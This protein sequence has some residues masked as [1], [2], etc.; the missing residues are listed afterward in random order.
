MA[1]ISQVIPNLLGGVSQQPDPLKLPGQVR[2][3]ENAL[4]DPTFGCRKRP[5]TQFIAKLADDIPTDARWFEIFRDQDERY[6]VSIYRTDTTTAIRVW[7]ADTG[8]ERTVNILGDTAEYLDAGDLQSIKT[9]T[10]NDYTLLTN[11]EKVVN[12]SNDDTQ[13][14]LSEALIVINQVAYNTTYSIDF[15]KTD[16][17][18]Q[19]V[20]IYYATSLSISPGTFEE[21]DE[22]ACGKAD[23]QNFIEDSTDGTK[24]ELGF[25]IT[26]NC[27][28]TQVQEKKP[29]VAYPTAVELD[30]EGSEQK[31]FSDIHGP[32]GDIPQG[33]YVYHDN[34]ENDITFRV[35]AK[36]VDDGDGGND[37]ELTAVQI[38]SYNENAD[39]EW[40][41][42][43]KFTETNDGVKG[44]YNITNISRGQEQIEYSYKSSYRTR[45]TLTNGGFGWKT[46]D[47]VSVTMAGK[48]YKVTVESHDFV[49]AYQAESSVAYTTAADTSGGT[50][51]VD[52]IVSSLTAEIQA[53]SSYDAEPIGNVIY[54]KRTDD[55]PFN[56]Q[57]RGG[58]VGNA[59]YGIKGT[60]NDVSRLPEQGKAGMVLK[61]Q[62][63]VDTSADDYYVK[64]KPN[65][66]DIPGQ[67]SW[68]ETVA[69]GIDT[70]LN[71]STMPHAMVREAD[72]TFSVRPL[73][74]EY[75]ETLFWAPRSAG[76][77][78]SNPP[79]TFVGQTI[80]QMFF[81]QNRL[82]FLSSDSVV[83][84]QPGDYFNFFAGS[85][86]TVSDA[87]PID[88]SV[89][90]TRPATLK[91]AL[92]TAQGLLLFAEN[93]QFL[94]S[95]SE[96]AFG[97]STVKLNEITHYSYSSDVQ[98]LETGVSVMF[99][100][101]ADTFSKVY[102][103]ALDSVENRPQVSENSRIVPE[104][105][106]PDITFATSSPN[107]SLVIFG[108]NTEILYTF[109]FYNTG[110]ER[111]LAGWSKWVMP[112]PVHLIAFDHDT[113]YIVLNNDGKHV[114]AKLE[115]LDD[116]QTSPISALG[117]NFV[118]RLDNYLYKEQ[119]TITP[120]STFRSRIDLPDGSFSD[121]HVP[122]IIATDSGVST[123]F[124]YPEMQQDATGYYVEVDNSVSDEN[125]IIGTQYTMRVEL[126]SFFV[127][128][129]NKAD[130]RN[131]PIVENVYLD[132]YFSGRYS[133]ELERLGYETKN[134][135]LDV[136][137][138]DVYIADDAA[139]DEVTSQQV[140][141]YCRGDYAKLSITAEDPLPSSITSYRWEGHYNNRGIAILR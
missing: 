118:P 87:D 36:V 136:T 39:F 30:I 70:T 44:V 1:A 102:E 98:P 35:E 68:E 9:L 57:T 50:L 15:L 91:A 107:N 10:I 17:T 29:G 79:P 120:I 86:L 134:F 40:K 81:Y 64:F 5:P 101:E 116:P 90:S 94:M 139:I 69:P 126:P 49:Y 92:G 103:M 47:K 33:A 80:K 8:V 38:K 133:V 71:P 140:P 46:G 138:S 115:M 112:N 131:I 99:I 25:S 54:I 105:I 83:L 77:E 32:A 84:S 89:S 88:M 97:P 93:S 72:G 111:N 12:M 31:W 13:L 82:G 127:L 137:P 26:T 16:D 55:E 96:T 52:T 109:K 6:V 74:K 132:I 106:P 100:T 123:F 3:A 37:F 45:V 41:K 122:T 78:K 65:A 23:Q 51:D 56:I 48:T 42:G 117:V 11:G 135:D 7:E 110:N 43:R 130:R 75:S 85:A 18:L 53:L 22:G 76:D 95:T 129:E 114:L 58:T 66:G 19:Q 21:K 63:T 124:R 113:G 128:E 28:P 108:N 2:E 73:T 34:V 61:V 4:L 27:T 14:N 59:L 67:G 20:K 62:N 125:F 60:V 104:Y 119:V 24:T 141:V 121:G